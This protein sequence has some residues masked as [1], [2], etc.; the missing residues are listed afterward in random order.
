MGVSL[1]VTE[2]QDQLN[3]TYVGDKYRIVEVNDTMIK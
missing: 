3:T 2:L 1:N